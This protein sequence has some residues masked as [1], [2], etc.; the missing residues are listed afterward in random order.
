MK[1]SILQV[2]SDELCKGKNSSDTDPGSKPQF[3]SEGGTPS[4][5]PLRRSEVTS[6]DWVYL[7]ASAQSAY[8]GADG[9]RDDHELPK[10]CEVWDA[11]V[12]HSS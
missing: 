9:S 12:R 7:S 10:P 5:A 2:D 6:E 1:I 8:A 3:M 11:P 4:I